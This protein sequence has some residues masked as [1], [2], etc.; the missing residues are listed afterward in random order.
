MADIDAHA[1]YAAFVTE[2]TNVEADVATYQATYLAANKRYWQGL[3]SLA[4]ADIGDAG[5]SVV[6]NTLPDGETDA[7]DAVTSE[8]TRGSWTCDI[9]DRGGD[10][11]GYI[12]RVQVQHDDGGGVATYRKETWYGPRTDSAYSTITK[13]P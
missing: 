1:N 2:Q 7:W 3:I 8:T 12:L 10:L 9:Y 13:E 6:A 11:P 5:R 4:L